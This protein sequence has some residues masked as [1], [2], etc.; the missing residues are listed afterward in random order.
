MTQV[1]YYKNSYS[2]SNQNT[3]SK[4]VL[5]VYCLWAPKEALELQMSGVFLVL[6]IGCPWLLVGVNDKEVN[7]ER[8]IF[9]K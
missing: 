8:K 5:P 3:I 1:W 9:N 4:K 7:Y 2:H 6:S